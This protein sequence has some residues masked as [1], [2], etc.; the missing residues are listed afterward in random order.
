MHAPSFGEHCD[1]IA[2]VVQTNNDTTTYS[3]GRDGKLSRSATKGGSKSPW[4]F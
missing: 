4:H 1:P 3:S 2:N